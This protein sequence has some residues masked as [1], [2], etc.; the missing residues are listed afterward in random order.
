MAKNM[1]SRDKPPKRTGTDGP[2]SNSLDNDGAE[3]SNPFSTGGGGHN[4]EN[5]VQAAFVVL[6]LSG[7]V[8]P[9]LRPW[10]IKKIKLQGRYAGFN[11][12]DFVAF[13]E[14]PIGE[15]RAKLLAQIKHSLSITENDPVFTEVMQAAWR[16]FQDPEL[17]DRQ[18]DAIALITGPLSAKD[19][20]NARTVLEWARTS[21]SAQEFLEKVTRTKFSSAAKKEKLEAFRAQ[22]KKANKGLAVDDE[23]LWQ[24]LKCFHILG[25]DLDIQSG[26]TLSLLNSHIAQFSTDNIPGVW[27]MVAKEV[28]FFNQNAGTITYDTLSREIQDS[29]AAKV[30]SDTIPAEFLETDERAAEPAAD[31]FHGEHAD[32]ITFASLLGSW[33]EKVDGDKAVIRELIEPND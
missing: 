2:T 25:Y 33:N 15:R 11:T 3:V 21:A 22:L 10:P 5:H 18:Y 13:V 6:M 28:E 9:C 17:F 23:N 7:G 8:A 1:I 31:Y 26:V 16:D 14:E 32:A 27:A 4:F 12:D 20:D 30:P 19:T 29:F 24:F